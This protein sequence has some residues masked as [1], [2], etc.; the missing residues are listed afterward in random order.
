[1]DLDDNGLGDCQSNII[2]ATN[3]YIDAE[4][5]FTSRFGRCPPS[6]RLIWIHWCESLAHSED[7]IHREMAER[8]WLGHLQLGYR[9]SVAVE[10]ALEEVEGQRHHHERNLSSQ[11]RVRV[12]EPEGGPE[13]LHRPWGGRTDEVDDSQ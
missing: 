4:R 6:S 1:M 8:T 10:E 9:I 12:A 13:C 2:L 5:S 3:S 11:F 7:E